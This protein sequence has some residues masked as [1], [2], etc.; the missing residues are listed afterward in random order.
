M[1]AEKPTDPTFTQTPL[2]PPLLL[3]NL[4]TLAPSP[5]PLSWKA[6]YGRDVAG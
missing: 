4:M 5:F 1:P 3:L 6:T 2:L